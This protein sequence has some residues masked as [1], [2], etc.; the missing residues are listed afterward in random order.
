MTMIRILTGGES[1]GRV[2]TGIV[3][4]LPAG[5]EIAKTYIDH[6]LKRRQQGYGRGGRM[7]IES[8]TVEIVGG[9]R[10]G[11]TT[12]APVVL[13][14]QNIDH[15]HWLRVLAVEGEG[16][17]VAPVLVPRPGH[18]DYVGSFKYRHADI[19]DVIERASARE[20]AIRV[21]C[22]TLVRKFLEDVG[23]FVG[24]HVTAIGQVGL[25]DRTAVDRKIAKYTKASCGAY[26]VTEEAD[27]SEVRM[28]DSTVAAKAIAAVRRARKAGDTLG[29][30]FEIIVTGVPIGLGSYVQSDRKLDGALAQA[31]MAIPAV[32][33]VEFGDA[34][35][36]ARRLGSQVHDAFV[37]RGG[38]IGRTTNRAGGLEGGVTNGEPIVLRCA[39]KPIATLAAPLPSVN[40]ATGRPSKGRYERS[41]ACA[42]PAAGVIGE[43]VVAPVLGN[44]FL[45]K[46]GGDSMSEIRERHQNLS[47]LKNE[48]TRKK[49]AIS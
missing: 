6:Q 30:I 14:I 42:V 18:A 45:E 39:M 21:A 29:G 41:D 4:G 49:R 15:E 43:A 36:N 13:Q 25:G 19:R 26:K 22:A 48:K 34:F 38:R 16:A 8:D 27:R 5:L 23:M 31:L 10:F 33:G 2:L 12:G 37:V 28:L 46:F 24:S 7:R 32:K 40:I 3:E 1:H 44:A 35:E 20:T 9:V 11:R 47:N 17:D